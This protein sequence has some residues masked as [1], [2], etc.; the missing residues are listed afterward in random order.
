MSLLTDKEESVG[1]KRKIMLLEEDVKMIRSMIHIN[2][3]DFT[4]WN[5]KILT[6]LEE[7][8][9]LKEEVANE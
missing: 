9:K 2:H 6:M 7:I 5:K 1:N 4:H 3:V 8:D